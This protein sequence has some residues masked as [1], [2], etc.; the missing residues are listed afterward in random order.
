MTPQ[1]REAPQLPGQPCSH[2]GYPVAMLNRKERKDLMRMR[3]L[4]LLPTKAFMCPKCRKYFHNVG[5]K[6]PV[7]KSNE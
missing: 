3:H 1:N 6:K 4:G 2:C 7:E 5:R